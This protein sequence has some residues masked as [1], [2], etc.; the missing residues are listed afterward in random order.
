M[1]QAKSIHIIGPQRLEIFLPQSVV[2][3]GANSKVQ[4]HV[5]N[6]CGCQMAQQ[7]HIYI[8]CLCIDHRKHSHLLLPLLLFFLVLLLFPLLLLFSLLLIFFSFLL[9]LR[10]SV[11][12]RKSLA[13]PDLRWFFG[14]HRRVSTLFMLFTP[15]CFHLHLHLP[16]LLL[17]LLLLFLR[18]LVRPAR[19]L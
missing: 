4:Q 10:L 18:A 8:V 5:F 17:L 13:E 11:F 19:L 3:K 14:I 6:G 12:E 7:S 2:F 1:L 16:L 9:L 15:L